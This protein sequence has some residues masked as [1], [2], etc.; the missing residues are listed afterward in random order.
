MR[1]AN[2]LTNRPTMISMPAHCRW[3]PR[4]R[5]AKHDI[6]GD[7]S[8]ARQQRRPAPPGCTMIRRQTSLSRA[9]GNR[10]AVQCRRQCG[11]RRCRHDQLATGGRARSVGRSRCS[12]SH[13]ASAGPELQLTRIALCRDRPRGQAP[14]AAT[15][16]SRHTAPEA[17]NTHGALPASPRAHK[18]ASSSR[19]RTAPATSRRIDNVM[20]V[21]AIAAYA[22]AKPD[23]GS[24]R[25]SGGTGSSKARHDPR[26]GFAS[27]APMP[28]WPASSADRSNAAPRQC[29]R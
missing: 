12:G 3:P 25:M 8:K 29:R 21:P 13:E 16:R 14:D 23:H 19:I 2:V 24:K 11:A 4:N 15:T 22:S 28:R 5:N 6:V 10:A 17:A 9:S 20:V 7:R 1:S 18:A 27:T 26:S